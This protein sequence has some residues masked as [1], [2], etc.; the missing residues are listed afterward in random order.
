MKRT[1]AVVVAASLATVLS[2]CI[3]ESQLNYT[4]ELDSRDWVGTELLDQMVLERWSR[5]AAVKRLGEPDALDEARRS[6]GYLRCITKEHVRFLVLV[7]PTPIP[8]SRSATSLCQ[9]FT[10]RF[11]G[12]DAA[13]QW[14]YCGPLAFSE[15]IDDE[16]RRSLEHYL[17]EWIAGA[18]CEGPGDGIP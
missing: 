1:G 7:V 5:T 15:P 14:S 10:V 3:G 12:E 2:G 17:K 18:T 11:D 16:L 9:L 8:T 6:I 4:A 13:T